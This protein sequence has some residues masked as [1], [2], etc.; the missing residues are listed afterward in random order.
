MSR[1]KFTY[2]CFLVLKF[3]LVC[4]FNFEAYAKN[5]RGKATEYYLKTAEVLLD[6][7]EHVLT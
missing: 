6:A 4:R 3:M 5:A 1:Q 2:L 7:D